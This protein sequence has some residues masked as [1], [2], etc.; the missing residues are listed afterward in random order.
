MKTRFVA[1][2]GIA[3]LAK[4]AFAE[5]IQVPAKANPWLAG[6]T[7]GSVA[8]RGDSAPQE[9]PVTVTNTAIEGGAIYVFSAYGSVNHGTTLPFFPPDGE[10][11]ASHYLGAENG[12]AD[13]AAPFTGLIGVFLDPNQPDQTPAPQSLDFE[14]TESRDYP[15]LKPALKQPFFI[16]NGLTA[17]GAAKQVVAPA[18]ATRLLLGVMDEYYWTDN[19]GT[20]TVEVAKVSSAM[21]VR[22]VLYPSSN[23]T[24]ADAAA[25]PARPDLNPATTPNQAPSVTGLESHVFIAIEIVW[26]SEV[27]HLYQVQWTPSLDEPQWENLEPPVSGSGDE[28]SMFDSTKKHPQGFYRVRTLPLPQ[29]ADHVAP[30]IVMPDSIRFDSH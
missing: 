26:P 24:A 17:A 22:L 16:G 8:R 3:L 23:P 13:L 20:F 28:L 2:L 10:G 11:V 27:G 19:E 14:T 25:N 30:L 9:S 12:I 18:G 29:T 6:M 15:V 1:T 7:N 21:L 4:A 5:I